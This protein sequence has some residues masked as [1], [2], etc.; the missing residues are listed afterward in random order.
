VKKVFLLVAISLVKPADWRDRLFV[1]VAKALFR[2]SPKVELLEVFF[3]PNVGRDFSS[4]QAMLQKAQAKAQ[5]RDFMLF[6]NRSGHGPFRA[7]WYSQFVEQFER[8]D[9]VAICGSTITFFDHPSRAQGKIMPHV[10]TYAFLSSF[11]RLQMLGTEFPGAKET[12]RLEVITQ[13]EIGLSQF[14]L[15]KGLAIT[16]V[17]WPEA[18][19]DNQTRPARV[20]DVRKVSAKHCFYHRRYFR[21]WNY[22][23]LWFGMKP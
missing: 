11:A 12:Q 21:K 19:I 23:K 9:R 20:G 5:A 15:E 10:Q 14:F 13:G 4:F 6:Q 18:P 2:K 1:R 8:F 16:C 7:G 22:W 3:K 17:E